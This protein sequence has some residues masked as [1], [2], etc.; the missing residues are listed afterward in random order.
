MSVPRNEFDKRTRRD[1]LDRSGFKCECARLAHL[2]IPGI[3]PDGCGRA[4]NVR[5]G[6]YFEHVDPD[7]ISKRNDLENCAVLVRECWDIKTNGY[8][9][10]VIARVRHR[11]DTNY[12]IKDKRQTFPGSRNSKWKKRFDGSV[13]RRDGGQS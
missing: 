6:I 7:A 13:I 2:N 9:K 8:D 4:L 12:G 3:K 11:R 1:A 10:P 5:N